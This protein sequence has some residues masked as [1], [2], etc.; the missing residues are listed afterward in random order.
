MVGEANVHDLVCL[1]EGREILAALCRSDP[2]MAQHAQ[3]L[4]PQQV[5]H[6][7]GHGGLE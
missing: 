2:R 3:P 4:R 6:Q 7:V 1:D 5:G